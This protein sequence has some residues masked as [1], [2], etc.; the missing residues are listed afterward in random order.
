LSASHRFFSNLDLTTG[1]VRFDFPNILLIDSLTNEALSHGLVSYAIYPKAGLEPGAL[2]PNRA[3]IYFD[4]NPVVLTDSATTR[5]K[6]LISVRPEPNADDWVKFFPNPTEGAVK[7]RFR[8]APGQT[9]VRVLDLQGRVQLEKK[10][11]VEGLSAGFELPDLPA[12]PYLLEI[13][14]ENGEARRAVLLLSRPE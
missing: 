10:L 3:G 6:L 12:A 14:G 9:R 1:I 8:Q 5:V 4:F 7:L 11:S 2:I 13:F